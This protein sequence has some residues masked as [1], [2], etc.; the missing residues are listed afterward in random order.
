MIRNNDVSGISSSSS[1]TNGVPLSKK[2]SDD[3]DIFD[4]DEGIEP[5]SSQSWKPPAATQKLTE[6]VL[7][8]TM[9]SEWL[10]QNCDPDIMV[11][12]LLNFQCDCKEKGESI[13]D[14]TITVMGN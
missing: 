2:S 9:I 12:E 1:H 14:K 4:E 3:D 7:V 8:T 6:D 13:M 10:N 11:K 5:T